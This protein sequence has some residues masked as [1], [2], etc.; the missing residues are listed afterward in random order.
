MILNLTKNKTHNFEEG[1]LFG[2]LEKA[3]AIKWFLEN[4]IDDIEKAQMIALYGEW[5]SGKTSLMEYLEKNLDKEQYI[6][7]V[8]EAW[9]YEKDEHLGF[10][11]AD[12]MVHKL[13]NPA[14]KESADFLS[15]AFSFLKT[16][17]KGL[18]FNFIGG[19][20]DVKTFIEGIEEA[21]KKEK[22]TSLYRELSDFKNRFRQF[23]LK[24]TQNNDKKIIVFVD[25][26][27]RCEP[28]KVL[29]LLAMIKLFFTYGKKT[30]FFIGIDKN[31]VE[32]AV[33]VKYSAS[34]HAEE[35]LEKV[36]DITFHIPIASLKSSIFE[37]YFPTDPVSHPKGRIK[38]SQLVSSFL[39]DLNFLNPRKVKKL[40]NKYEILTRFKTQISQSHTYS[41]YIPN[42]IHKENP[43]G[44]FIDT[45]FVLFTIILYEFYPK[46][47]D[48]VW[49]INKKITKLGRL[50]AE[51]RNTD[52]R[53]SVN[54]IS[55][56][57]IKTNNSSFLSTKNEYN[58]KLSS[59]DV[60]EKEKFKLEYLTFWVPT[61]IEKFS[62]QLKDNGDY[63]GYMKQFNESKHTILIKFC[64]YLSSHFNFF[65]GKNNKDATQC[66][67]SNLKRMAETLL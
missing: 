19:K 8:F 43:S 49:N 1:D 24:T 34:I 15:K 47:Y 35:Y 11:L 60:N 7:L 20:Y 42:I 5:G 36:F 66:N 54:A 22:P 44:S 21:T 27:D 16:A 50:D 65:F 18:S 52:I 2:T 3:N 30:I 31:A 46:A 9:Q 17:T 29:E 57:L 6:P 45:I 38:N 62:S 10:S 14:D 56:L 53:W 33:E 39:F 13:G 48:E 28:D 64:Y 32:K 4:G 12:C 61:D 51:S 55:N 25:D 59:R 67:V 37:Y 40:L 58:I 23:E 41:L 63:A 26:L